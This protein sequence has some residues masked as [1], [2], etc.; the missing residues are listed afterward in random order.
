MTHRREAAAA[1]IGLGM[2][3]WGVGP[4]RAADVDP[5][6]LEA[7]AQRIAVMDRVKDT[8]LAVFP[9]TG[10]GG[11]SGVVI[12]PDGY[13]L[14][15][16][17]VVK[18]CGH[19]MKCGM[20]D[21]R[22]YDAVVVGV[23]PTGDIALIKLFGR[24][25]FP[26]AELGDSDQVAAGDWCFAMGNPF[27]L[28]TDLQPTVTYGIVSGVH[29]YQYPAGSILE[30]ADCIQTDASINPG[31]SG[32]PLF[33]AEGRL[34]GINGRGSFEKRGRVNVGVA[35]AVSIN[36]IKNFLGYL[37]SGRIVDHATLGA[38]V[39]TTEDGRVV[40][41]QVLETSDAWRRGLR[42][43]D[44]IIRFGGRPITT[45]NAFKNVLGI[46]PKGWRIPLSFRHEGQRY[47]VLVRLAGVHTPDELLR[48]ASGRP[49]R[50]PMPIP[51]PEPQPDQPQPNNPQPD[52]PQP[53]EPTPEKTPEKPESDQAEPDYSPSGKPESDQPAESPSEQPDDSP[54][55]KPNSEQPKS[56]QPQPDEPESEQPQPDEP[57]VDQPRP[58]PQPGRVPVPPGPGRPHPIRP[59]Q[60]GRPEAPVP[61]I[62]RKHYEE[63]R[64][65]ANYYF[66]VLHR[67]R[68]WKAWMGRAHLDEC[69]GAWGFGGRLP[70]GSEFEFELADQGVLLTLPSVQ[71][72]W[73]PAEE[74]AASLD[75]PQSGGLL[76]AVY[77]WRRLVLDGPDG[78][79][80]VYYLGTTPLPEHDGLVDVLVAVDR[81]VECRLYFDPQ[82][83]DLLALEMFPADD[84]D[85]CELYF[86]DYR[87]VEGRFLPGRLEAHTGGE[88]F[89]QFNIE[90]WSL[91]TSDSAPAGPQ[92]GQSDPAGAHAQ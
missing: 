44:E 5:G 74:L 39:H 21:G 25:D 75:P 13:A 91:Q 50:V 66:N 60:I 19:A 65:Y 1:A 73:A 48:K 35:Y 62:V 68:V 33:D 41:D 49:G 88:L 10:R 27:L 22:I 86:H 38:T 17:H 12:S 4:G 3:L 53:G 47:D 14:T 92:A 78:F 61:E 34:I 87:E 69:G 85:P 83:G 89:A 59:L 42:Y 23:D 37:H 7:E 80:E 30:Y 72:K 55:G 76:L 45:A 90:R 67:D 77:L 64:G 71:W 79:G 11:G 84:V 20:A 29:R 8:V 63:K 70:S 46:Y 58:A 51:V 82:Q 43:G 56:E 15:N 26:C 81:G 32:G 16:F 24:D 57:P 2:V 54:S 52:Q 36:Q 40:V 28:A 31:N 9:P 6:V 18:P